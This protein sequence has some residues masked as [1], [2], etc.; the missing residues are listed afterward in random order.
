MVF[1]FPVVKKNRSLY[2]AFSP[3]SPPPPATAAAASPS[4]SSAAEA[5]YAFDLCL[6]SNL[7]PRGAGPRSISLTLTQSAGSVDARSVSRASRPL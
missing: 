3:A 1:Y 4:P 5:L 7:K 6:G 2:T